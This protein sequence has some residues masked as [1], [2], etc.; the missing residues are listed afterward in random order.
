M[1]H[2]RRR[3]TLGIVLAAIA[4]VVASPA[5]ASDGPSFDCSV[6]EAGSIEE[7]IC[8]DAELAALDR[9]LAAAYA[10]A[11]AKATNE[12]PPVLKAE[13]RGWIKGRDECWKAEDVGVCVA[14][15][16]RLRTAELQAKYRLVEETGPVFYVCN[17]NPADQVVATLFAT[18]PPSAIAERGDQVSF[19]V[20]EPT[21]SGSKYVGRNETLWEHHGEATIQWGHDAPEMRC[22]VRE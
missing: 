22:V 14:N 20:L 5:I 3:T 15:S 21:A 11:R 6:V 10:G 13:Q 18:D 17:D 19:M 8:G 7:M 1:P 2:T 16:Y 12:H 9:E 4:G